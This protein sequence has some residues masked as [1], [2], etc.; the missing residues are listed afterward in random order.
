MRSVLNSRFRHIL[1]VFTKQGGQGSVKDVTRAAGLFFYS[2]TMTEYNKRLDR[3]MSE[4][5]R[6]FQLLYI[7]KYLEAGGKEDYNLTHSAWATFLADK[8]DRRQSGAL[9]KI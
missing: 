9:Y 8:N 1:T 4:I 2:D 3:E 7:R 6:Y 5:Q